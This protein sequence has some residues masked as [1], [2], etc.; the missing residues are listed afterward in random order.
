MKLLHN[1]AKILI[2]DDEPLNIEVLSDV[3]E[4]FGDIVF[5]TDGPS[6]L[7]IC[8]TQ[9]PDIVLLD[10]MMPGMDGYTVCREILSNPETS[11]I[12]VIFV[13]ALSQDRDEA[14]A[15][16]MGAVD[17]ITKPIIAPVVAARVRNHL[18]L[19]RARDYLANIAFVDALTAIP[20]RR[21][22]DEAIKTEWQRAMRSGDEM[23]LL[24]LDIDHFKLFNDHYGHQAGDTCLVKVAQALSDAVR[25]P[26]DIVARYGGEE[27]ACLLPETGIEGANAIGQTLCESIRDLEIPHEF[28]KTKDHVTVSVGGATVPVGLDTSIEELIR[29]AD[30]NLYAAKDAGR[31]RVVTGKSDFAEAV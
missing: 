11:N 17:Y 21:R 14:M 2:V 28:S 10:V 13:T 24:L 29:A 9:L 3:V 19:K 27:F 7:E 6:A 1:D 18:E 23:S 16:E 20:N 8:Q 30:T 4:P 15:I 5:A 12:P 31:D 26:G 22:F 25:R